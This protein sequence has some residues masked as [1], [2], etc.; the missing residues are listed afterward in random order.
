MRWFVPQG[1]PKPSHIPNGAVRV[2]AGVDDL[3]G[4]SYGGVY[5]PAGAYRD[6]GQGWY[7]WCDRHGP[8]DCLRLHAPDAQP[9]TYQGRTWM[10]P[11]LL[12][13]VADS[14]QSAAPRILGPDGWQDPWRLADTQHTLRTALLATSSGSPPDDDAI[15]D[16]VA[17]IMQHTYHLSRSEWA[18]SGWLDERLAGMIIEAASCLMDD[19]D[20]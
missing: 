16:L 20:A 5:D 15:A 13:R 6:S 14:W 9:I 2:T 4:M 19:G 10:V 7:V 11:M 18:L 17:E 3:P 12:R 8:D 1:T